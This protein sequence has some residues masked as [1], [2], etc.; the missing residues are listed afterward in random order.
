[1]S[2]LK[3]PTLASLSAGLLCI[4]AFASPTAA[5]A[6]GGRPPSPVVV[7]PVV[8][9]EV[10]ATQSFVGTVMPSQRATVGSAVDGR[11]IE[12]NIEEGDRVEEGQPLAQLLTDTISLEIANA[13]SELDLKKA[14]LEELENGTRPELLE[15][16]RARMA[17]AK[18]RRDY[19]AS[20]RERLRDLAERSS[21]VTE[22]EWSEA[23]SLALEAEESA[24]EAV[25]AYEEAKIGPRAEVIAQA[26][27]EVA[28]QQAVVDRLEDQRN[29]YT[30]RS[31]FAGYVVTKHTEVGQWMSS[32]GDVADVVGVDI[33]EVVVQ[34]LERSV[35]YIQVG[36]EVSVEIPALPQSPF[37]GKVVAVVPSADVRART[38]PVKV[39]IENQ[40]TDS[41]PMIKPG[42]FAQV[43]L[44]VG[45]MTT[46]KLV[47]KDAVVLSQNGPVVYVVTSPG[48][49]KPS[50]VTLTPV[51]L[52]QVFGPMIEVEA[53]ALTPGQLIVTEGNER[54]NPNSQ[55]SVL[56]QDDPPS[57]ASPER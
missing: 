21:A 17:S 33:V 13:S 6:Q 3:Q 51:K 31:R 41:G 34:V 29:K 42:M 2:V 32:G 53:A 54:L 22:D 56:R 45:N 10:M 46:S 18:A 25:A 30:V 14:Q 28:M 36:A 12:C 39:A 23:V 9:Q 20:R 57:V 50:G 7:V 49:Q 15:Q 8:E 38:F 24:A 1:M 5:L 48:G 35:P 40:S 52:G 26:K 11:V 43:R 37:S 16:Y 47:P 55:V 44:P 27:A 4:A 19:L